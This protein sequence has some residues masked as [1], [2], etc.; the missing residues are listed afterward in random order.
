M[1]A[2]H[3]DVEL[4]KLRKAVDAFEDAAGYGDARPGW[5]HGC[6]RRLLRLAWE[7]QAALSLL[8]RH[9]AANGF[10]R[11]ERFD[12]VW[13]RWW[14]ATA[15]AGFFTRERRE[16]PRLANAARD[17]LAA[18][19]DWRRSAIAAQIAIAASDVIA[20]EIASGLAAGPME[21]ELGVEVTGRWLGIA[22]ALGDGALTRDLVDV[23]LDNWRAE[24]WAPARE[25]SHRSKSGEAAGGFRQP[26]GGCDC[27]QNDGWCHAPVLASTPLSFALAWIEEG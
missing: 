7:S 27:E 20:G 21:R 4:A 8:E 14:L 5:L 26:D 15:I 19:G 22:Q 24:H 16:V 23:E 1:S 18:R 10:D 17:E 13:A 25:L 3:V 6:G 11:P 9:T 2:I 12:A